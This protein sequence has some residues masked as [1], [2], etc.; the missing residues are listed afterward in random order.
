MMPDWHPITHQRGDF[1]VNTVM[2]LVS[3]ALLVA[4]FVLAERFCP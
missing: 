4:V 1:L 3:T 2:L